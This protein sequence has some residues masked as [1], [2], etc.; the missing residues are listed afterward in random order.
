MPKVLHSDNGTEFKGEV[1]AMLKEKGI[2]HIL[3]PTYHPQAQGTV[4]CVNGTLKRLV[5]ARLTKENKKRYIDDLQALVHSYN[6]SVHSTTGS[7]PARAMQGKY[8][9]IVA[10]ESSP[11]WRERL[12]L[13]KGI[14]LTLNQ[15]IKS[16]SPK[17]S[18]MQ[19]TRKQSL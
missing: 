10:L 2:R 17:K 11:K 18:T 7:T 4:E 15:G 12:K 16:V 3:S 1:D 19:S 14:S 5:M 6:H 9:D 8:A 13:T